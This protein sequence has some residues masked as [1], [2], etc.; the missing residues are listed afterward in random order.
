MTAVIQF[1]DGDRRWVQ[2]EAGRVTITPHG[3]FVDGIGI[4]KRQVIAEAHN[5][6]GEGWQL[7]LHPESIRSVYRLT[8][9]DSGHPEGHRR[10]LTLPEVEGVFTEV[11]INP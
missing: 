8:T 1:R 11:R 4:E 5:P 3:L 7:T 9:K 2:L 10:I 6:N